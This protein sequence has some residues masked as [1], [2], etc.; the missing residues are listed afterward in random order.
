[1]CLIA[2]MPEMPLEYKGAFTK[3]GSLGIPMYQTSP[4]SFTFNP[5]GT[6]GL[7]EKMPKLNPEYEEAQKRLLAE[8]PKDVQENYEKELRRWA[9]L[10]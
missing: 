8:I 7:F 5:L 9:T 3:L 10:A 6:G 1:M 4:K 2:E